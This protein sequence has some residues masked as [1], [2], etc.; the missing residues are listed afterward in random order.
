MAA[1]EQAAEPDSDLTCPECGER[2][3]S[4]SDQCYNC[5]A[6]VESGSGVALEVWEWGGGLIAALGVFLSPLVTAIPAL[7]CASRIYRRKP[8]SAYGILGVVLVT[9]LFWIVVPTVI[10]P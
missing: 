3:I 2:L 10:L 9:V 8:R 6:P 7:Y 4:G 5:G 1:E